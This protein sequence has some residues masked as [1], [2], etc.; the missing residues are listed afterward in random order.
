MIMQI[1]TSTIII[2][3][4]LFIVGGII[5][6]ILGVGQRE[7][8][9]VPE[10]PT[11]Q[12]R[13]VRELLGHPGLDSVCANLTGEVIEIGEDIIVIARNQELLELRVE[14]GAHIA[15]WLE[16]EEVMGIAEEKIIKL[17]EIQKGEQV[18]IYAVITEQGELIA[19]GITVLQL[20]PPQL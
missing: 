6:L 15:R 13:K 2:G 3:L 5:G 8:I 11:N 4:V 20:F 12:E 16:P 9:D 19:R 14:Q 18:G 7:V 1:K 17:A 10:P